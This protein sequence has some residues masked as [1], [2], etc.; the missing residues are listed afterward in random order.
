MDGSFLDA[1]FTCKVADNQDLHLPK[2]GILSLDPGLD[3]FMTGV[4]TNGMTFIVD[5]RR[6]KVSTSGTTSR[7]QRFSRS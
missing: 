5:G 6:K 2:T 1:V 3:N 7:R 4:C